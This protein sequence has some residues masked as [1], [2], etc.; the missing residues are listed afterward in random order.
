MGTLTL[1]ER[2]Y[3][4]GQDGRTNDLATVVRGAVLADLSLRG[5]VV[6][7]DGTVRPS[8]TARTG[9]PV[10]DD[11]LRSM[12]EDKARSWRGWM[13]RGGKSTLAAVRDRLADTG[14]ITTEATR[15]MGMFPAT[16]V[17]VDPARLE[18]QRSDVWQALRGGGT[19]STA[20][21][22]LVA[23]VSV[24]EVGSVLSRHDRHEYR[25]RIAEF[26]ERAGAAVPALLHVLRHIKAA[27]AGAYGGGG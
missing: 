27:R 1:A 8:P 16:K 23:L 12:S 26:T 10:L 14:M 5:C 13:R 21:A 24:G 17:T 25:D 22:T 3:L 11:V 7:E 18:Q 2:V 19:V 4:L 9:D 15:T 6:E 20:D